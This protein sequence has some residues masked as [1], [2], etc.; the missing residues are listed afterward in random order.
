MVGTGAGPGLIK[1]FEESGENLTLGVWTNVFLLK[2]GRAG[3]GCIRSLLR[4][5]GMGRQAE[6]IAEVKIRS[7]EEYGYFLKRKYE[8]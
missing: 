5:T 2:Q 3:R 4:M 6:C 7:D 1:D 8:F